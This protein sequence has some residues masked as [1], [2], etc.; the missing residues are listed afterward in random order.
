MKTDSKKSYLA[1]L[2]KKGRWPKLAFKVTGKDGTVIEH[3]VDQDELKFLVKYL[4]SYIE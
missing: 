1:I 4:P 2:Y 3:E